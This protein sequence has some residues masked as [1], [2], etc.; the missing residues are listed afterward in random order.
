MVFFVYIPSSGTLLNALW[1]LKWKENPDMHSWFTLLYNR[2]LHNIV[3]QLHSNK[4]LKKKKK[5]SNP[6]LIMLSLQ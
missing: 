6:L 2:K 5:K 4:N 1:L 3:K